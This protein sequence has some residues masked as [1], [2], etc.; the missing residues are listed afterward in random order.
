MTVRRVIQTFAD[1]LPD[2]PGFSKLPPRFCACS[3]LSGEPFSADPACSLLQPC[4]FPIPSRTNTAL[5]QL[6]LC[7]RGDDSRWTHPQVCHFMICFVSS[8]SFLTFLQVI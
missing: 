6:Q 7:A 8:F 2:K 5:V 3:C 4:T 1:A